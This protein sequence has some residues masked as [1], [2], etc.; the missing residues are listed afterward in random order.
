MPWMLHCK[1]RLAVYC[2]VAGALP[3][4]AAAPDAH[5]PAACPATDAC[6]LPCGRPPATQ[7]CLPLGRWVH[8]CRAESMAT[9][10]SLV[11]EA[12]DLCAASCFPLG[13]KHLVIPATDQNPNLPVALAQWTTSSA[14]LHTWRQAGGGRLTPTWA[15]CAAAC[16]PW[17]PTSL[18]WAR[19]PALQLP[20]CQPAAQRGMLAHDGTCLWCAG[21]LTAA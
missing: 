9:C 19:R 3:L 18:G 2:G 1:A 16:S 13:C 11:L 8:L 6:R 17:H 10:C 7:F 5:C 20:P 4:P 21:H 15:R 12:L 14:S